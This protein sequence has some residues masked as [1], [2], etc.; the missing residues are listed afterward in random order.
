MRKASANTEVEIKHLKNTKAQEF[1][2]L[3][4]REAESFT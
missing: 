1:I 4:E 3:E 2:G